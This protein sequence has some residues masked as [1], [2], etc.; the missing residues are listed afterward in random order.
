MCGIVGLHYFDRSRKVSHQVVKAMADSIRHRGP[1]DE[2]FHVDGG[3]GLGHRRLSIIDL[4]SGKQPISNEDDTC[5][6]VFNGEIYNYKALRDDL[7]GKGHVF[8]THTDTEAILHC[9]EQYGEDC[10]NRLNGMFAFAIWDGNRRRLFLAR[11]HLGIKPLYYHADGDKIVFASEMKAILEEGSVRRDV[12]PAAFDAYF[13]Y[14]YIPDPLSIFASVKKLQAGHTLTCEDG[15]VTIRRFWEVSNR[16]ESVKSEDQWTEELE[17]LLTDS[18]KIQLMS[19]VPLGVFLSGGIDSSSVVGMMSEF[20]NSIKTFSLSGGTGLYNELPFAKVVADRYH[21]D[22]HE[23]VVPE[24]SLESLLPKV[25]GL[26]DEPF[27][28]SS[29]IPTFLVSKLARENVKVALSGEGGDELF[30]GYTWH[31]KH[32]T[33]DRYRNLVPRSIRRNI[34]KNYLEKL[35]LS[36]G[37]FAKLSRSMRSLNNY[38]LMAEGQC[39]D[40]LRRLFPDTLKD[41]IYGVKASIPADAR[42]WSFQKAYE[43]NASPDALD[44]ALYADLKVYLTGDL[45]TKV[46]RMSMANSLEVRVPLLDYRVVEMAARM[47]QNLKLRGKV[48]KHILRKAMDKRLPAA[49]KDRKIKRG[50]SVPVEEWFRKGLKEYAWDILLDK[51]TATRGY[52]RPEGVRKLLEDQFKGLAP[53]GDQVFLM[54]V[55]ELWARRYLDASPS[56]IQG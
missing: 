18:V 35:S 29:I 41:Q 32:M 51:R 5:H 47:P 49:I 16:G 3:I 24:A 38:S 52:F 48:S 21:T 30:G 26:L 36:S 1:D 13:S 45:L 12:D 46:D 43:R 56:T 39:F 20:S 50:F 17:A 28:D 55:F 8:K 6:I 40:V 22:H 4:A 14:M 19:D 10:V 37:A 11:D 23:L 27:A 2:G 42:L 54:L 25:V 34:L 33:I 31:R 53:L 44:N 7:I 9:Y 15:K